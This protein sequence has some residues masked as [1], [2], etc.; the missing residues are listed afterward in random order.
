LKICRSSAQKRF[1]CDM[2]Q[3]FI[4]A[5]SVQEALSTV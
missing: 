1:G 2:V 4:P 3:N 5:E